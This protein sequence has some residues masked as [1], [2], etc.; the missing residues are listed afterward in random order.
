MKGNLHEDNFEDFIKNKIN[1]F[2][3][4][5]S[6]DMW[7]RIEGVIPPKPT[8]S[9]VKYLRPI[10]AAATMT[11]VAIAMWWVISDF[12]NENAILSE[13]LKEATNKIE[14]LSNELEELKPIAEQKV[15]QQEKGNDN[16]LETT[17]K[18][19][20][21]TTSS[22]V[23]NDLPPNKINNT[24]QKKE[25]SP[26]VFSAFSEKENIQ[27]N[28]DK[29]KVFAE[30]N[31]TEIPNE[32]ISNSTTKPLS[33]KIKNN[34]STSDIYYIED[35]PITVLAFS[36]S[37]NE[38]KMVKPL[39][40]KAEKQRRKAKGNW[41]AG[42]TVRPFQ[43]KNF[44]KSPPGHP[45][46]P[47]ERQVI[48]LAIGGQVAYQFNKNW[49]LS[50][51]VAHQKESTEIQIPNRIYYDK[52]NEIP[53]DSEFNICNHSYSANSPYGD[54]NINVD[55]FRDRNKNINDGAPLNLDLVGMHERRSLNLPIS[56]QYQRSIK[57]IKLGGRLGVATLFTL[58]NEFTATQVNVGE[59]GVVAQG[60]T[61]S[62]PSNFN[63]KVNF[64][65]IVGLTAAY[66]I[67][68][69]WTLSVEPTAYISLKNKF[70]SPKGS[71]IQT[72]ASGVQLG[73]SY[74]F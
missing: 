67:N 20:V 22:I 57:K 33:E 63:K 36:T 8:V 61:L 50:F 70:R 28:N 34:L 3:G 52:G 60:V 65:G 39:K 62:Q 7:D 48:G 5:P 24:K 12:K 23:K 35:K 58:E 64:D 17:S 53:F 18:T 59:E 19:V 56:V 6:N 47:I 10:A 41:S 42:V 31:Q 45:K 16:I 73:L 43:N 44:I 15:N 21:N 66:S 38:G 74:Q 4:T 51:G 27:K 37:L 2:D 68:K 40:E 11:L 9:I 54:L 69:D 25:K 32:A 29:V 14:K 49:S 46:K 55:L 72:A 26:K 71:S 1:E 30:N 13:E